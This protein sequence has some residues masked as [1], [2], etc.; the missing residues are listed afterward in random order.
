MNAYIISWHDELVITLRVSAVEGIPVRDIQRQITYSQL[1]VTNLFFIIA[2]VH[3]AA[4][5][6]VVAK[7][8]APKN[9]KKAKKAAPKKAAAKKPAAKKAAAKKWSLPKIE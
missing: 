7:K 1:M 8:A 2:K 3:A 6:K 5:K 4:P 9:V